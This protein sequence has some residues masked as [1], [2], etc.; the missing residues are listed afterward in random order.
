MGHP[1]HSLVGA[2]SLR[3]VTQQSKSVLC[4]SVAHA[5][6]Y[7]GQGLS[8]TVEFTIRDA[9]PNSQHLFSPAAGGWSLSPWAQPVDLW[10]DQLPGYLGGKVGCEQSPPPVSE[11]VLT[12]V[13]R[14]SKARSW[15]T[16]GWSRRLASPPSTK[17]RSRPSSTSQGSSQIN[18]IA[19]STRWSRHRSPFFR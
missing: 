7:G 18:A 17:T 11:M 3:E 10:W 15:W 19:Q 6:P 12:P 13:H 2:R 4:G 1:P 14:V 16:S 8:T 5:F 9:V